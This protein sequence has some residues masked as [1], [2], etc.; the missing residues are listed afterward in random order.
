MPSFSTAAARLLSSVQPSAM[1][2]GGVSTCTW[3]RRRR[4][5]ELHEDEGGL[6][7]VWPSRMVRDVREWF[8]LFGAATKGR[9]IFSLV[10][11]NGNLHVHPGRYR[12]FIAITRGPNERA[13][14]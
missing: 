2:S 13:A 14:L 7:T 6:E 10:I 9:L 1:P 5:A 12:L 11:S 4:D 8:I 3:L